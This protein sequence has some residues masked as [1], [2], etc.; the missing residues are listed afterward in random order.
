MLCPFFCS[1]LTMTIAT[2]SSKVHRS[3]AATPADDGFFP[4]FFSA[5]QVLPVVLVALI[6]FLTLTPD[7]VAESLQD[8]AGWLVMGGV[9]TLAVMAIV[10]GL[11]R[12][13]DCDGN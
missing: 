7:G 3:G 1:G 11:D 2:S 4:R 10:T 8:F 12:L 9:A 6:V 13:L 5:W